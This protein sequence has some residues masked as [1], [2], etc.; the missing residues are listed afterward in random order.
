M[1]KV[2]IVLFCIA[3]FVVFPNKTNAAGISLGVFPPVIHIEIQ[4]PASITSPI[5][6]ENYGDQAVSLDILFKP[7]VAKNEDG[8]VSYIAQNETMQGENPLI[9]QEMQVL[10][11][12]HRVNNITLSPGQQKTL[13]L[14]IGIPKEETLSDYYF[15][16]LFVSQ[17]ASSETLNNSQNLGGIATNVLL[18]IGPK[19]E[20]KGIIQEFSSPFFA[21]KGPVPFNVRVKNTGSHLIT[22]QGTILIK[23]MFGQTVGKVNLLP[24]NILAL[25]TRAIP[26][27]LQSPDS[28]PS[29]TINPRVAYW[30]ENFILGP[31][32]ATLTIALSDKGPLFTRTTY[33]VGFPLQT[34]I[35]LLLILF[36]LVFIRDRLKNRLN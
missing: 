28:T 8:E 23:N 33:F 27:S 12:G 11:N 13:N 18:S 4:P 35:G 25:S 14:H 7:F 3:V 5:T 24:V 26:D 34:L 31:Y 16:I 32:T 36:V 21:E 29:S 17:T 15:S 1:Y 9:F 10:D 22:P 2:L 20:A 19:G 30:P 6:I